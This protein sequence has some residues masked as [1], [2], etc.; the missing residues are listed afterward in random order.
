MWPLHAASHE[1]RRGRPRRPRRPSPPF[2]FRAACDFSPRGAC[3]HGPG[4]LNSSS[5]VSEWWAANLNNLLSGWVLSSCHAHL[6]TSAELFEFSCFTRSRSFVCLV[7]WVLPPVLLLFIVLC[8]PGG[9]QHTLA[10]QEQALCG[11]PAL[12]A[13][14]GRAL[15]FGTARSQRARAPRGASSPCRSRSQRREFILMPGP[16]C[17]GPASLL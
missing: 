16:S 2:R 4:R 8:A 3:M 14:A 6:R 7:A 13:L 15:A 1:R 11:C 9:R 10:C 17:K 12:H 5:L